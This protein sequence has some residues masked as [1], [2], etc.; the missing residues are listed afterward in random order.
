MVDIVALTGG[1]EGC[2]SLVLPWTQEVSETDL[3]RLYWVG[4]AAGAGS[5]N[6]RCMR[7]PFGV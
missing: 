4:T 2:L 6:S 5:V 1:S 3:G 7:F